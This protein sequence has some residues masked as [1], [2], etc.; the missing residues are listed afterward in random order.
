MSAMVPF[1]YIEFYD[2][3]RTIALHYRG[4]LLLLQ[5]AFDEELDEY[6]D[7]YSVYLLPEEAEASLQESSWS[8]MERL[9]LTCIGQVPV[10]DVRFDPTKRHAL[11]ASVL[12][13]VMSGG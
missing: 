5:S 6:P 11:D 9:K 13:V 7:R 8:F 1:R 3:P 10:K 2:V 4:K 12:D